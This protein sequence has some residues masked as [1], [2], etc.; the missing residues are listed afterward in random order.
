VA[1]RIGDEP[2]RIAEATCKRL[3]RRLDLGVDHTVVA[4]LGGT[5]CGKSSLFNALAGMV[6]AEVGAVRP[7]T[8]RPAACVWGDESG[9]LLEWLGF[10][11][12]MWIQRD[13][14]LEDHIKELRG[15][16]L[17]DL[18][19]I[20]SVAL[21]HREVVNQIIPLADMLV[22]VTDPVK[23]ADPSLHVRYLTPMREHEGAMVVVLNQTDTLHGSDVRLVHDDLAARLAAD[24]L[25]NVPV[26]DVS[27]ATGTGV[28]DLRE[29]LTTAT[30]SRT[31][32]V[33]RAAALL[34]EAARELGASVGEPVSHVEAAQGW[35]AAAQAEALASLRQSC[36]GAAAAAALASGGEATPL[37]APH[38]D[39]VR[40]VLLTWL[41]HA[42]EEVPSPWG[43]A[44][45][46]T[47]ASSQNIHARLSELLAGIAPGPPPG[48]F[49]RLL[50]RRGAYRVRAERFDA[51]LS[52][53]LS[54]LIMRTMAAP[55]LAV[56]EDWAAAKASLGR[57]LAR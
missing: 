3:L 15:L 39:Q 14:M 40:M 7:T 48:F 17:V 28:E 55:T 8:D 1:Q 43:P 21:A 2:T 45:G 34:R 49:A 52:Q 38:I 9:H 4:I 47:L 54:A 46:H 53:A 11:R 37:G 27:A 22:W 25:A 20:D 18:P 56:L 23:Y 29:L 12:D 32:P 50:R 42:L 10:E 57:V 33:R 35:V 41:Q 30:R 51:D 16:V 13:S 44:V 5:G 26:L 31:T 6:F 24:G 19:D 36:G